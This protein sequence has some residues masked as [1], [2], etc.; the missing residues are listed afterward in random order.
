M[1]DIDHFKKIN[2]AHGHMVGD[3]VLKSVCTR[4]REAIRESDFIARYG[5]EEFVIILPQTSLPDATLVGEKIRI[6]ISSNRHRIASLEVAVSVSIVIK[7]VGIG[8]SEIDLLKAADTALYTAKTN[9]RNRCY[10]S[11]GDDYRPF[12]HESQCSV[13]T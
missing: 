5:G 10:F 13:N 9:G 3:Q 1:I 2:D 6:L 7:T 12:V 4:I 11:D 8:Q